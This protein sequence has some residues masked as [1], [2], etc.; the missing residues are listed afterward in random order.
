[1]FT[2]STRP[3]FYFLPEEKLLAVLASISVAIFA[4][5]LVIA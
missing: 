4:F 2:T 5:A 1:M 3:R